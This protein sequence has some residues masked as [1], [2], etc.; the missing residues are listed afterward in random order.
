M[1]IITICFLFFLKLSKKRVKQKLSVA[2]TLSAGLLQKAAEVK[3]DESIIV[4]IRGR[5]CVAIEARYHK[6]CYQKYTK[7]LSNTPK[8]SDSGPDLY[9]KAFDKF[10]AEVIQRRIINNKEILL[11]SYLLR[12][13]VNCAQ[14]IEDI[15]SVPYQASR[16][17]KRIQAQYP[18][19]VFHPS[20]TRNKGTLVYSEDIAPGELADD[21]IDAD[22]DVSDSGDET[23]C[24]QE[25]YAG[26]HLSTENTS[27]TQQFFHVAMDIRK[28]L[29]DTEGVD[30]WPPDS[31]DLTLDNATSSI[32]FE[33]FNFISWILGYSVEPAV[34]ERVEVLPAESCKVLSICQDLV[35][36]ASKGKKVHA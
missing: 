18:Q 31:N 13:F 11:L 34:N 17:K 30:S 1:K 20:K 2:Q 12:K 26:E 5:D 10:C 14:E 19:V 15:A 29:Q 27:S 3:N 32:P 8:E 35:Y 25:P 33:L 24:E 28:L 23:D 36:A 6:R 7:F 22:P 16:L 4:H 9:Q 21:F